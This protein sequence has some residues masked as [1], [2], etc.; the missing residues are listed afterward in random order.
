METR[1]ALLCSTLRPVSLCHNTFIRWS[2]LPPFFCFSEICATCC[3]FH[4]PFGFLPV[5]YSTACGKSSGESLILENFSR[6]YLS[7]SV[8]FFFLC[9]FVGGLAAAASSL[10][11]SNLSA[12]IYTWRPRELDNNGNSVFFCSPFF[13]SNPECVLVEFYSRRFCRTLYLGQTMTPPGSR[14]NKTIPAESTECCS[15]RLSLFCFVVDFF[16]TLL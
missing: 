13:L 12:I 7:S 10:G 15:A 8:F 5:R 16:A 4:S 1:G 11:R 2:L 9:P 3:A 6:V 14:P